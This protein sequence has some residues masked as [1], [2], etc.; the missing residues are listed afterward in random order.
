MTTTSISTTTPT[1]TAAPW[2]AAAPFP[3]RGADVAPAHR[4]VGERDE[5]LLRF[6][7]NSALIL[8][9]GAPWGDPAEVTARP[10][11]NL[12][13][14]NGTKLGGPVMDK[15][16]W[17]PPLICSGSCPELDREQRPDGGVN[18]RYQITPPSGAP[19]SGTVTI[20]FAN[21]AM[22]A[23][24]VESARAF[25]FE[26]V[27]GFPVAHVQSDGY[28]LGPARMFLCLDRCNARMTIERMGAEACAAR[29]KSEPSDTYVSNS[30]IDDWHLY[31]DAAFGKVNEVRAALTLRPAD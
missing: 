9:L 1:T 19:L 26:T 24:S 25:S 14:P 8:S 11:V 3:G 5:F 22:F 30:C 10:E 23:E 28:R 16:Q 21:W 12:L 27:D 2:S 7:D 31:L 18:H 15:G 6:A 29:V 20:E 17:V 13:R 4:R